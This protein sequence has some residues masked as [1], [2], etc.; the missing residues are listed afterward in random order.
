MPKD[1]RP[2]TTRWTKLG[3][4]GRRRRRWTGG[5]AWTSSRGTWTHSRQQQVLGRIHAKCHLVHTGAD[6]TPDVAELLPELARRSGSVR[7][8]P[9]HRA[10]DGTTQRIWNVDLA[11]I[12]HRLA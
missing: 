7:R 12:R 2:G 11:Q 6:P 3:G 5:R 10:L 8:V 9:R 4:R 1:L